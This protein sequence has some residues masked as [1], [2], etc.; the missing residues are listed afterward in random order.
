MGLYQS[1]SL[2]QKTPR[3]WDYLPAKYFLYRSRMD[4]KTSRAPIPNPNGAS[5][6]IRKIINTIPPMASTLQAIKVDVKL[7]LLNHF[8][9]N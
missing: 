1:S 5:L 2:K 8:C 3:M 9:I 6:F 4:S 7:K